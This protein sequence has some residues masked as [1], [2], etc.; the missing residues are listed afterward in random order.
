MN[1]S[2]FEPLYT[3]QELM[4]RDAP[5]DFHRYLYSE[6]DWDDRLIGI[7]GPRGAGKTTLLLQNLKE[8]FSGDRE[9]AFYLSLDNLWVYSHDI[10]E[11][12]EY[13]YT[14]GVRHL[15]LDEVHRFPHWQ[16]LL[17]NLYDVY[18]QLSIVFTGSSMLEINQGEADN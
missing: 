13:L 8:H 15:F 7:K 11:A 16:T 2:D 5:T 1:E 9:T 4:L 17:K 6:I 3:Q 10:M 12:V 18:S 14:H